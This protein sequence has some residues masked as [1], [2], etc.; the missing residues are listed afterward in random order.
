MEEVNRLFKPEFINRI[1]EI[2]VFHQLTKEEVKG[3]VN[4]ML[5]NVAKVVEDQL[6]ITLK[7]TPKLKEFMLE[8]GYDKKYGARPM[9]RAIQTYIEDEISDAALKGEFIEGDV[10][11]CSIVDDKVTFAKK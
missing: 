3:I 4:I 6:A 2:I 10:I 11:T 9:R 1:D 7:F 8:K 5:K